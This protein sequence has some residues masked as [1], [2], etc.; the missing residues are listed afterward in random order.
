MKKILITLMFL[1][2]FVVCNRIDDVVADKEQAEEG[3]QNGWIT[4]SQSKESAVSYLN[5]KEF[6]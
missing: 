5:A 6:I 4:L 3:V 1:S 2:S